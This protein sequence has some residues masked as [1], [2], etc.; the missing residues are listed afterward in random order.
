LQP[1]SSS[2]F[3]V[4]GISFLSSGLKLRETFGMPQTVRKWYKKSEGNEG[5]YFVNDYAYK[6]VVFSVKA[7]KD[8]SGTINRIQKVQITG[9]SVVVGDMTLYGQDAQRLKKS[10]G[11]VKDLP[12]EHSSF[13]AMQCETEGAVMM[14]FRFGKNKLIDLITLEYDADSI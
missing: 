4:N 12:L 7:G 1:C 14:T 10:L 9:P 6:D 8:F 2:K 11:L 5:S 3:K 13:T